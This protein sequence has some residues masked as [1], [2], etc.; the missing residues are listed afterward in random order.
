MEATCNAC[1][2]LC[3][4]PALFPV[5]YR[6]AGVCVISNAAHK[7]EYVIFALSAIAFKGEY[8]LV[9]L[10][11]RESLCPKLKHSA[12]P[13]AERDYTPFAMLCFGLA[14]PQ[15]AFIEVNLIPAQQANLAVTHTRSQRDL[16]SNI[17][18]T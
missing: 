15:L 2:C 3:G 17:E 18:R 12:N 10:A 8:K 16:Y 9:R 4:F 7:A 1:P 14:H 5:A 13:L 6:L 11:M